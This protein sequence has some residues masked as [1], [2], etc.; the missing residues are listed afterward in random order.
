MQKVAATLLILLLIPVSAQAW[1][2]KGHLMINRLAIDKAGTQLP[3]FMVAGRNQLIYDAYEP[4]RWREE[5]NSPMNTVQAADHFFDSELWGPIP[6]IEPDRFAFMEK[7]AARKIELV[8]IGYLPYAMIEMYDRLRNSFRQWRNAKTPEDREAARADALVYA[9]ILG[10]YVAD[11]SNPMHLSIHYDAWLPDAPN[12]KGY[13]TTKGLHSQF[14]TAYVNAAVNDVDV[15]PKVN[16]PERL[17]NV[18]NSIKQY[19]NQTFG[20]LDTLYDLEKAGDLNPNAP[21]P[22][23]TAFVSNE[24]GRAATMLGNL[25]YTAWVESA[26]PAAPP[27]PPRGPGR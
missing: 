1:G 24:I 8:K 3:E 10:H 2:E 6:T 12:P 5:V 14:E 20:H 9:G 7:V 11:G 22:K 16:A 4:D 17:T 23:G 25:W 21:N 18:F 13:R 19:L 15:Q 27:R 26:E